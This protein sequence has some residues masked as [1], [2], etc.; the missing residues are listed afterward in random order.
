MKRK[1]NLRGANDDTRHLGL[2]SVWLLFGVVVW[3]SSGCGAGGHRHHICLA[4]G[5]RHCALLSVVILIHYPP[6]KQVLTVVAW[7]QVC[8]LGP[9][10]W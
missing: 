5:P 1:N 7:V 4:V 10:S 2:F 9:V 3:C 8:H 6:C